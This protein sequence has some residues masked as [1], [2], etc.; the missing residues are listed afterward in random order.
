MV[1]NEIIVL[2]Q[3]DIRRVEDTR[4]ISYSRVGPNGQF[5]PLDTSPPGAVYFP[6]QTPRTSALWMI[7]SA[8]LL[9]KGSVCEWT[10]MRM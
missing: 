6:R 5:L 7:L 2:T 8:M 10:S 1:G 3:Q 4:V 9:T